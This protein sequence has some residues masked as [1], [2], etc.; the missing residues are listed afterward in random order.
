[1]YYWCQTIDAYLDDNLRFKTRFDNIGRIRN[2]EILDHAISIL[3]Y[4]YQHFHL[5]DKFLAYRPKMMEPPSFEKMLTTQSHFYDGKALVVSSNVYDKMLGFSETLFDGVSWRDLVEDAD[6]RQ[7][8]KE[9]AFEAALK[10]KAS[11]SGRDT[12]GRDGDH[13]RSVR[14]DAMEM[15]YKQTNTLEIDGTV[16]FPSE[17]IIN[18]LEHYTKYVPEKISPVITKPRSSVY[19]R[20]EYHE[21]FE[22]E[23]NMLLSSGTGIYDISRLT[24]YQRR[25]VMEQYP[26][27]LFLCSGKEIV[28]G[29][30]LPSLVNIF[31]DKSF[32][33]NEH[34]NVLYQLMGRA[35]RMGRSY[36]AT[37]I[38]NSETT[39]NKI[40]D[41][42]GVD[43]DPVVVSFDSF[44]A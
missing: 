6:K 16:H 42:R 38:V 1:V 39:L 26:H 15:A 31:I 18:S 17:C 40:I 41:F 29:T 3:D 23:M 35:G 43:I 9:K 27:L 7:R 4:L 44:Y 36:H 33:D 20:P 14:V 21:A 2:T 28:F 13:G 22:D 37:I 8:D 11:R 12:D 5:L 30:N 10:T 24:S 34:P 32:G 25:L 19:L